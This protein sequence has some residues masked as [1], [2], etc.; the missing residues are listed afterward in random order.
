ML[1]I[2]PS[3]GN[4]DREPEFITSTRLYA[5]KTAAFKAL[6]VLAKPRLLEIVECEYA[7]RLTI[8]QMGGSW[9]RPRRDT[10]TCALHLLV[11]D[12]G[13]ERLQI[14]PSPELLRNEIVEGVWRLEAQ[15][16]ACWRVAHAGAVWVPR[17][18]LS[19]YQ[20]YI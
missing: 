18:R 3:L 4:R 6:S 10:W 5:S 12:V 9:L 13:H 15:R 19:T 16:A 14:E 17:Y 1:I 20:P 11:E 7:L 2:V 8:S